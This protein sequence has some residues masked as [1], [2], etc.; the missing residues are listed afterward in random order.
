MSSIG[1][2]SFPDQISERFSIRYPVLN[3]KKDKYTKM[4]KNA[5]QS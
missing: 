2:V 4:L 1:M 5:T 3:V